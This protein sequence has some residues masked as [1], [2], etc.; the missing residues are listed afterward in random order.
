MS[1]LARRYAGALLQVA[2]EQGAV[3]AVAQDL[4]VVCDGF[5]AE[6]VQMALRSPA[7]G[8]T[9]RSALASTATDGRHTLVGNLFQALARRQRLALA[10]ELADV[11]EALIRQSRGEIDGE[12]VSAKDLDE[13]Q[14]QSLQDK[15]NA[16]AGRTVH[17][18]FRQDPS[19]IGGLTLRV[20][21]TLYD[22]SVA[23]SLESLRTRMLS[24]P[25]QSV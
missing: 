12:V 4:R 5:A 18:S 25:L 3:D 16:L 21:N 20:G 23:S 2:E 17:L 13:S 14:R 8:S 10:T 19:L 1:P 22:A 11:Y 15:A 6:D 9:Q 24:A 7:C